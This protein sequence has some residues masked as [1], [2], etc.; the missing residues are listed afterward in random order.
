MEYLSSFNRR[1]FLRG[2]GALGI[3]GI[4]LWSGGCEACKTQIENRPTR[5]NIANLPANDPIIQTYKDAVTAMQ[6]L[7]N[8]DARNWTR[9]AQIHLNFCP[10]GNWWFLPWHRAYLFY[11]ERICRQLTGNKDFALPYWNW[12]TSPSMPAPFWGNGNPL[13]D[14]TRS[15]TSSDTA[16][17]SWVSA[18]VI[19]GIL[20]ETN[21]FLFASNAAVGQRDPA[22]SGMLEQTPHNNIHGWV[23][24]DMCAYMS[25]L[26]PVFWCHHNMLDCLWVDWNINRGNANTNDANWSNHPFTEFCD[27][28]GAP[29]TVNVIT[30]VLYP[31]FSYQFEA[32]GPNAMTSKIAADKQALEKFLRA[33]A[34]AT[35]EFTKRFELRQSVTTEALKPT[36]AS[37]KVERDAFKTV[38]ETGGPKDKVVLTL[39]QVDIPDKRDFFVRVFVNKPDASPQTPIED[40]HYAG[41]FGFFS[42]ESMKGHEAGGAMP[43]AGFL[44]DVT[45]TLRRLHQAGSLNGEQID[46]NLVT[47]PYSRREASGQ[48]VTLGRLELGTARF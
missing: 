15:I 21:F 24:G 3:T 12:T 10:H 17:P 47:V 25:P 18:P 42:D 30:T 36:A 4:A 1:D 6:N 16:D 29:V 7:P 43:K 19:D 26:D 22:G 31:I 44:V 48:R 11:F 2:A 5:R 27:E 34:P 28:N 13:F 9:Q 32:C 35:L 40:P 37:I 20:N 33:G 41:S 46:V 14:S 8:G 45:P 38:L 23:C 39:D